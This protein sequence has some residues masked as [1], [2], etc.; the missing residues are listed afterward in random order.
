MI[1]IAGIANK[2]CRRTNI[3]TTSTYRTTKVI[4]WINNRYR[5][6]YYKNLWPKTLNLFTVNVAEN[7]NSITFPKNINTVLRIVNTTSGDIVYNID[8]ASYSDKVIAARNFFR[9]FMEIED[10]IPTGSHTGVSNVFQ[11][12]T[13]PVNQTGS[14]VS[15]ASTSNFDTSQYVFIK[16]YNGIGAYVSESVQLTGST[17]ANSTNQYAQVDGV[18]KTGNTA[19]TINITD[20]SNNILAT[21]DPWEV[22]PQ[23]QTFQLEVAP[24]IPSVLSVAAQRTFI[25]F[26]NNAD[27]AIFDMDDAL[28]MGATA[29]SFT[30]QEK[31]DLAEKFEDKYNMEVEKLVHREIEGGSNVQ[32]GC[33]IGRC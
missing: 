31:L 29:D 20:S 25:P 30:E 26:L 6:I 3:P 18:S 16:G 21:I 15:F 27:V 12:P 19:G 1:T 22:S 24:S 13:I 4:D 8:L 17:E 28:E 23:Y 7:A 10:D 33:P 2:V 14:V 32:L 9:T 5:E 11:Q